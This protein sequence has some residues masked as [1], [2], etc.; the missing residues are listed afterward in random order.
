MSEE[1]EKQQ[2]RPVSKENEMKKSKLENADIQTLLKKRE[3]VVKDIEKTRAELESQV[4]CLKV[5]REILE[6]KEG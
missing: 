3:A 6:R 5:I 4:F 1:R 2:Q